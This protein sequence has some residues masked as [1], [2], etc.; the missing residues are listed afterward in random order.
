[1]KK[2][3]DLINE[4]LP[5]ISEAFPWDLQEQ[6]SA[7]DDILL[8]DIREPYEFQAMHIERSINVP[9]GILESACDW[10]YEETVPALAAAREREVLLIC[11]SGNRSALAAH[12]LKQMGYR[13]AV[14]LKTGLKGWNDYEQPLVD[15]QG[16]PVDIE[17]ADKYF[18]AKVRP[19][20]MGTTVRGSRQ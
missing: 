11:R 13:Q 1:M 16:R 20:Q 17:R 18:E 15:A 19:E 7:G 2:Y 10:G 9:R 14:S 12:T 4:V 8:V 6:M 5:H 3:T